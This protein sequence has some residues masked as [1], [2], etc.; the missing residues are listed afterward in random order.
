MRSIFKR[1]NYPQHWANVLKRRQFQ[2]LDIPSE[3]LPKVFELMPKSFFNYESLHQFHNIKI[4]SPVF[5]EYFGHV[6]LY[7]MYDGKNENLL[8]PN[9]IT[10][11]P[12]LTSEC[13]SIYRVYLI[14]TP[15]IITI[16]SDRYT[17]SNVTFHVNII[18]LI[19]CFNPF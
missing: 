8:G 12:I 7:V 6:P 14:E 16:D 3:L 2:N 15:N 17:L 13:K 10:W 9:T 5:N 11:N 4:T 19:D 18:N 1:T